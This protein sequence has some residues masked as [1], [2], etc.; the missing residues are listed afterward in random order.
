MVIVRWSKWTFAD[1][2]FHPNLA[3]G[4]TRWSEDR[5]GPDLRT[6]FRVG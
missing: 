5:K 4:T 1:A 6:V 2:E 3:L